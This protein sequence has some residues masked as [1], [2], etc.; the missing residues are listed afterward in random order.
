MAA[1][2]VG[3]QD[4]PQVPVPQ[5]TL[6]GSCFFDCIHQQHVF[7]G[8]L[9]CTAASATRPCTFATKA[10]KS[11][12]DYESRPYN[13]ELTWT[14]DSVPPGFVVAQTNTMKGLYNASDD[15]SLAGLRFHGAVGG[16]TE[17]VTSAQFELVPKPGGGSA[18][19]TGKF[20]F[21]ES[22]ASG[23]YDAGGFVFFGYA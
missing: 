12:I 4:I 6:V 19:I 23:G 17:G 13:G 8:A 7:P 9:N 20:L 3:A 10:I 21:T 11:G 15:W 22:R 18:S 2:G 16:N 14:L 1:A 5:L